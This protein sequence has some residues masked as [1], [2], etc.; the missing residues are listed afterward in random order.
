MSQ[1]HED[2]AGGMSYRTMRGI[3]IS[4]ISEYFEGSDEDTSMQ[5]LEKDKDYYIAS[6]NKTI[7]R[8]FLAKK[9]IEF[10]VIPEKN[11]K[12]IDKKISISIHWLEKLKKDINNVQSY[13]EFLDVQK[14]KKWHAIKLVPSAAEGILLTSIIKLKIKELSSLTHSTILKEIN[15]INNSAEK[16]FLDLLNLNENSDFDEAEILRIKAYNKAIFADKKLKNLK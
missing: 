10:G 16:I 12:M 13:S 4:Q 8:L 3:D 15:L 6:A 14:Y 7:S 5:L 9:R 11:T 1:K 2:V